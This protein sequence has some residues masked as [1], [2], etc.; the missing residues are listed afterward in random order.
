MVRHPIWPRAGG[1]ELLVVDAAA[2][3]ATI[4][5]AQS[6]QRI[7]GVRGKG[8]FNIPPGQADVPELEAITG[9]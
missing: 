6:T 8:D 1:F 5:L 3:H 2:A 7:N 9:E 4:S